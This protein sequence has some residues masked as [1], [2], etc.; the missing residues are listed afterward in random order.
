MKVKLIKILKC[1]FIPFVLTLAGLIIGNTLIDAF[2]ADTASEVE[3][4][5]RVAIN[6]A[7]I[8][9]L[10]IGFLVWFV[11]QT[12]KSVKSRILVIFLNPALYFNICFAYT[13]IGYIVLWYIAGNILG[14]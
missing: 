9:L 2:Y 11:L 8:S 5:I 4:N 7:T 3:M 14:E 10:G 12:V 1:I 13:G 6:D